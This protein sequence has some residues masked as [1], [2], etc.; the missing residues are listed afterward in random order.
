MQIA[1]DLRSEMLA[2]VDAGMKRAAGVLVVGNSAGVRQ[3]A[4]A[5]RK[6]GL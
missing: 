4:E 5:L 3:I 1:K 2:V 6:K